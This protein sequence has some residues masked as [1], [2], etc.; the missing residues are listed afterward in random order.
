MAKVTGAWPLPAEIGQTLDDS[1]APLAPAS[2]DLSAELV[3]QSQL[4]LSGVALGTTCAGRLFF[5][6]LATLV[7]RGRLVVQVEKADPATLA[8]QIADILNQT[9]AHHLAIE[10]LGLELAQRSVMPTLLLGAIAWPLRGLGSA[11]AVLSAMPGAPSYAKGFMPIANLAVTN[12]W[13]R[14]QPTSQLPRLRLFCFHHAGGAAS[15]YRL[16]QQSLPARCS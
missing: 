10:E 9:T 2:Q 16:W 4:L 1:A 14:I 12:P 5:P 7:V 15:A 6:Q 11:V 8:V 3:C 13:F